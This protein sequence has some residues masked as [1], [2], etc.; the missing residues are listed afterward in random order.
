MSSAAL[1]RF[2][3]TSP[4]LAALTVVLAGAFVPVNHE[5]SKQPLVIRTPSLEASKAII[6]SLPK[7]SLKSIFSP[8]GFKRVA[9]TTITRLDASKFTDISTCH[10]TNDTPLTTVP[11]PSNALEKS[12]RKVKAQAKDLTDLDGQITV[13]EISSWSE[14]RFLTSSPSCRTSRTICNCCNSTHAFA[15]TYD[16]AGPSKCPPPITWKDI[17]AEEPLE[18]QHWEGVYGL[19]P[20][21]TVEGW[22]TRSSESTPSLSPWDR[23][24]SLD[25]DDSGSSFEDLPPPAIGIPADPDPDPDQPM[26]HYDHLRVTE[27]L[28]AQQYW[29]DDWK[30]D[31]DVSRPFDI[32]DPSTLGPAMLRALGERATLAFVGL[33]QENIRH[34][35]IHSRVRHDTGSIDVPTRAKESH[36][37]HHL[38]YLSLGAQSS[39]L[40]AFA[41]VTTTICHLRKFVSAIFILHNVSSGHELSPSGTMHLLTHNI[42]SRTVE[43]FAD[44]VDPQIQRFDRWCA[45]KEEAIC[46]ARAGIGDS[47]VVSL[48]SLDKDVRD[49]FAGTFDVLLDILRQ[50]IACICQSHD[51]LDQAVWDLASMPTRVPAAAVSALLLDLLSEAA[52]EQSSMGNTA[53]STSLSTV[54]AMTTEPV[55]YTIGKWL[56]DGMPIRNAWDSVDDVQTL[57]GELFIED[58]ELLVMDPDFWAEGYVL[59]K[60][61]TLENERNQSAVPTFLGRVVHQ[62]LGAGKAVGLLRTMGIHFLSEHSMEEESPLH[63]DWRSFAEFFESNAA[64]VIRDSE[65]LSHLIE[66]EVSSYCL[67]A[68][69]RLSQVLTEGCDLA[70]HIAAIEGLF[71]MTRGDVLSNFTDALFAKMDS[72]QPWN[73]FHVLNSAFSDVVESSNSNWI[74]T[75]L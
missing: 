63:L 1:G 19:P 9:Q 38:G 52:E 17:L 12:Y 45:E 2:S 24:D 25:E 54:F 64:T 3:I 35:E 32:G 73:D 4:L 7:T 31:V 16:V 56:Q 15:E 70:R 33:E 40:G 72:Q 68:G 69:M 13:T 66:E 43:A 29:R 20:G 34:L 44:A 53:T 41:R 36:D 67:A 47:L 5:H 71:L 18:G 65:S 50:L 57:N 27:E 60:P 55:W 75:S 10:S 8:A 48:L 46:R 58:N 51:R 42:R 74:E 39:I 21:S 11:D 22:E 30:I 62:T 6:K 14:P 61:V 59:R 49:T 26:H 37:P 23:D 28:K